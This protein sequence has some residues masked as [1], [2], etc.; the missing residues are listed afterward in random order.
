M[1]T[2][3]KLIL[4]AVYIPV[5]IACMEGSDTFSG[6]GDTAGRGGSMARFTVHGDYLYT[7]DNSTLK[8]FNL[9][10]PEQPEYLERK[11]QALNFGIETIF[12]K[13][14]LLFIGS[15]DGMYIY[16]VARPEFPQKLSHVSHIRSC[17]PVVSSGNYAYVTL[18][19]QNVWCGS[20][21]NV[22]NIY[23][24][25]DIR[26]PELKFTDDINEP[27]GLGIDGNK[28]FVCDAKLG[29]KVYDVSNPLTPEWVDDLS[30][31]PEADEITPYDVIP[32]DGLLLT[33]TDMGLYQ[34]DYTG[35]KLRFV[36]RITTLKKQDDESK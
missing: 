12:N 20:T 24:I 31:L 15:Q 23:D 19:S 28:L 6:G 33:S 30:H 25:S 2:V 35:E 13:D 5:W 10:K 21:S 32:V 16:S 9:S 17:D 14:S 8:I 29:I 36:S 34:F 4:I 3:Y 1:K 27:K 22:L 26:N 11:D 7:V 18:N